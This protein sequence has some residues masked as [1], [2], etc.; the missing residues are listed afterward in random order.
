MAE[1]RGQQLQICTP[2]SREKQGVFL[3]CPAST[4]VRSSGLFSGQRPHFPTIAKLTFSVKQ[5]NSNLS[6]QKEILQALAKAGTFSIVGVYPG[7]VSLFSIGLAMN[8]NLNLQAGN[9]NHRKYIPQ[10]MELVQSKSI[11]LSGC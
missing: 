3:P 1:R 4:D 2:G 10:L 8:K 6:G 9:C 5:E 7:T 11:D